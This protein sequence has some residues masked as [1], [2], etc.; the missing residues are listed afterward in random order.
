MAAELNAKQMRSLLQSIHADPQLKQ[1]KDSILLAE[2]Q[3][4]ETLDTIL[5]RLT[6]P[7]T[8]QNTIN[9]LQW[10]RRNVSSALDA[11]LRATTIASED[12]MRK[13]YELV[14]TADSPW[15]TYTFRKWKYFVTNICLSA[16]QE[17]LKNGAHETSK[18]MQHLFAPDRSDQLKGP[19]HNSR[20]NVQG[21]LL[22]NP[23]LL[24]SPW[25]AP[26]DLDE[27]I[28]NLL[29]KDDGH[30]IRTMP[31]SKSMC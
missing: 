23:L 2:D 10:D 4:P 31:S 22:Y 26:D 24:D 27:K 7:T 5:T 20:N 30:T 29:D 8:L 18:G 11:E 25:Q 16:V 9:L 6:T 28:Q 19:N 13:S 15:D 3:Y 14:P 21:M 1:S 17:A 12:L